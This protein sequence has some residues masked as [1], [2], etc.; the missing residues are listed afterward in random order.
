MRTETNGSDHADTLRY[1]ANALPGAI[2]LGHDLAQIALG[3]ADELAGLRKLRDE[4][5][6]VLCAVGDITSNPRVERL[7][8]EALAM[9]DAASHTN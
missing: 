2:E 5:V 8:D 4:W 9:V 7:A 1:I 3:A 6:K